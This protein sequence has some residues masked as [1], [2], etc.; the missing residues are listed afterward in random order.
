MTNGG[1]RHLV[2]AKNSGIGHAFHFN[3]SFQTDE[4]LNDSSHHLGN[5][6]YFLIVYCTFVELF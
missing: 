1:S 2:F 4:I 5:A 3:A 6:I